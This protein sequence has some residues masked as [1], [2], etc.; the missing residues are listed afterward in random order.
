MRYVGVWCIFGNWKFRYQTLKEAIRDPEVEIVCVYTNDVTLKENPTL[1]AD[2]GLHSSFYVDEHWSLA[3]IT[4]KVLSSL[5]QKRPFC[6]AVCFNEGELALANQLNRMLA[7]TASLE[8]SERKLIDKYTFYA[9]LKA[10]SL[11]MVNFH[12]WQTAAELEALL[13]Q[14]SYQQGSYI[15]KP[16]ESSDSAGVYRSLLD[17]DVKT[18]VQKYRAYC[19]ES[20]RIGFKSV[21]E[22]PSLIM[23]YVD[24]D[25]VP[26]EIT[27]DGIVE[28]GRVV[29][30][31]IHEKLHM[32]EF[33]PFF[34]KRMV[35]PPMSSELRDRLPEIAATTQHVVSALQLSHCVFHLEYRLTR[36]RCIPI[37]CALRPGGG[38]IPHAIY[39]L[40]GIDLILAHIES[41]FTERREL[42]GKYQVSIEGATC[43]GALYAS[44][45]VNPATFAHL[46]AALRHEE[47]VLGV[48]VKQAPAVNPMFTVD[49]GLSLGIVAKTPREANTLFEELVQPYAKVVS[50][51]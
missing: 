18:S 23:E 29:V 33:A 17:E 13:A 19:Q 42:G 7:D 48:Y 25:G 22:Q 26:V 2:W 10:A 14:G 40:T 32:T 8:F 41:H 38:F 47:N 4:T 51:R 50:T 15:L 39:V 36:D 46:A 35:A 49:A 20:Q 12:L 24:Y 16:A 43:I 34:D 30:H 44:P 45:S 9:T 37:D 1:S 27:A 31:V 3:E 11:P 21:H 6:G 5:R 28:D